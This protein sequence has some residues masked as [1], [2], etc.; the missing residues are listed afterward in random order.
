MPI[1]LFEGAKFMSELEF[2][3][4]DLCGIDCS[5]LLFV[6]NGFN[7]VKCNN[8]GL[9]YLNPRPTEA[10]LVAGY[11]KEYFA[12][13][14]ANEGLQLRKAEKQFELMSRHMN[15]VSKD[16]PLRVLELGSG[17]GAFL[18]IATERHLDVTGA[19]VS[20]YAC[21]YSQEKFDVHVLQGIIEELA[22]ASS[23]FDIV[24]FF[25]VSSH[26]RSPRKFFAAISRVLKPHG[27]V[28]ARVGDKGGVW[29]WYRRGRWSAPEHLYHFTRPVLL[30]YLSDAGLTKVKTY[31]AF[32]SSFPSLREHIS[33]RLGLL[34][35]AVAGGDLVARRIFRLVGLT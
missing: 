19:D 5:R 10:E 8:C 7:T 29:Q 6:E 17:I 35:R 11:E 14:R 22:L 27:I 26:V 25:D 3:S 16:G 34:N 15:K 30:K 31:P 4:C 33:T 13:R 20:E 2:V 1:E 12:D 18:K 23:S 32:D 9:I 21:S 28:F 24:A